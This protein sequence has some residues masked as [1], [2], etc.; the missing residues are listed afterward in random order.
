MLSVEMTVIPASSSV[1]DVLP[2]LGVDAARDVAVRVF[3]D[4]CDF[5]T[6]LQHCL[7]IEFREKRSTVRELPRRN[8]LDVV[9]EFG[10]LAA[11]VGFHD[12]RHHV[13]ATPQTAMRLAEHRAGLA[14]AR[15]RAEVDAQVAASLR[16]HTTSKRLI[17]AH[18]L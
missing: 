7:D 11:T 8:H 16:R 2:P 3:V 10:D 4:Q 5:R 13:G 12:R 6:T 9:D 14:D 1:F 15:G 18:R 17:V